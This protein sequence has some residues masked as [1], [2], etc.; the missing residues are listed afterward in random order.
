[1]A[2]VRRHRVLSALAAVL[3]IAVGCFAAAWVATPTP[4]DLAAR[5]QARVALPRGAVSF[6]QVSPLLREAVVATE[7]ER[8]Y[9]HRGVDLIGVARALPYDLAHASLAQGAS[10]I[11]EQVAKLLYLRGDDRSPWRKLEDA[12]LALKLEG[13]YT[14]EQILAAYLNAAYF[15]EGATGIRAASERYFGVRPAELTAAQ[16]T[17]LAGLVQAPSA[18][19]PFTHPARARSRQVTVLRSLV[20][21]GDL[22]EREASRA[23]DQPL[24]LRGGAVLAPVVGVE[25]GP[26]PA[27][28]WWQLAVGAAFALVGAATLVAVR[29]LRFH[30]ASG[31]LAVR[32]L[33]AAALLAGAAV[34]IR[35]FRS[36]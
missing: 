4:N 32:A 22:S 17:L 16:A 27:F 14:K 10:T 23:L 3:L 36:A 2:A 8:F 28:V 29:G 25:L 12:T 34:V 1:M 31:M 33:S 26:G 30:R 11:T 6:D 5:V 24:R 19:D 35:S 18:Y 13:R 20:R 7:D 21:T 15:G 9:R